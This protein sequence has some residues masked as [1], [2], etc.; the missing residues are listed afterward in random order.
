MG[1][2]GCLLMKIGLRTIKIIKIDIINMIILAS[3]SGLCGDDLAEKVMYLKKEY[4]TTKLHM[5]IAKM[6]FSLYVCNRD[7]NKKFILKANKNA[8]VWVKD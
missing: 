1:A 4:I 5:P 3:R 6:I 2:V 7:M 8:D